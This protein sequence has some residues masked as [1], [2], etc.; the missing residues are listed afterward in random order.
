[1]G[2]GPLRTSRSS[3][4]NVARR[5]YSVLADPRPSQFEYTTQLSVTDDLR[6][7]KPGTADAPPMQLMLLVKSRACGKTNSYR[8]L[9]NSISK[10]ICP[11]IVVHVDVGTEL[12]R[13][14]L[15]ELWNRFYHQ[16]DLA[17]ACGELRCSLDNRWTNI[18]NPIV[19]AQYF[20]YKVGF[21]LD[22]TF[23]A[24]TGY[25]SVLPGAFSAYR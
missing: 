5:F 25:M 1:M 3:C 9:Y 2:N 12:D 11:E 20:E 16:P 4:L 10:I 8:W 18:L 21:Q 6:L 24:A 23:E 14:A 19:A 7:D 15:Y 13:N 22:R 17:G